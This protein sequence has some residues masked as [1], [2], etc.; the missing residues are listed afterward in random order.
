MRN[1]GHGHKTMLASAGAPKP[2]KWF[3]VAVEV[4]LVILLA[5]QLAQ[6]TF[7]FLDDDTAAPV[8]LRPAGQG[9]GQVAGQEADVSRLTGFDPFYRQIAAAEAPQQQTAIPESSLKIE[10]FGLRAGADG[11]GS[12]IVKMQGDDDQKLVRVGEPVSAGV[13]L[14]GVYADRLEVRRRGNR[15]A[16]YLRPQSERGVRAPAPTR[17]DASG[18]RRT[19][20]RQPAAAQRSSQARASAPSNQSGYSPAAARITSAIKS[21]ALT[22]VRRNG[23]IS[24]F[25]L[26][27]AVPPMV[28]ALGLEAGDILLKAN[29]SSLASF[30]R[31]EE[32]GE[33]LAGADRLELEIERRGQT[34]VQAIDLR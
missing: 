30:E 23:R 12:A 1:D 20:S 8:A 10:V 25:R 31:I 33:E 14:V 28:A 13:T 26:P 22:P 6:L 9:A 24:G 5:Y 17:P 7:T 16:V 27:D 18:A 3:I 19:A 11:Q 4:A 29:G 21:L 15:E 34:I 2:V 32:L